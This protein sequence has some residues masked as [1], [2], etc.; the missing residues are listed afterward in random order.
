[1]IIETIIP[2]IPTPALYMLRDSLH[3]PAAFLINGAGLTVLR[4]ML[5]AYDA[6]AE[7][8]CRLLPSKE[9]ELASTTTAA[10]GTA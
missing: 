6:A 9:A 1:M 8:R 7:A 2:L 10:E 5:P 4:T 3:L